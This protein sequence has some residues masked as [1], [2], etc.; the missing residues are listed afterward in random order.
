MSHF[1]DHQDLAFA[2]MMSVNWLTVRGNN[3]VF[4]YSA[5]ARNVKPILECSTLTIWYSIFMLQLSEGLFRGIQSFRQILYILDDG[6]ITDRGVD[7]GVVNG[8]I[9]PFHIE[10]LLNKIGAL[11]IDEID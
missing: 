3:T 8:T 6:L 4:P 9:R 2:D 5:G 11:L 1:S 7:H 10:I